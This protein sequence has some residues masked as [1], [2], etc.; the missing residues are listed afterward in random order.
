MDTNKAKQSGGN[1]WK[2]MMRGASP[3]G[4]GSFIL[5]NAAI[6]K[7]KPQQGGASL[8]QCTLP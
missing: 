7:T 8:I 1:E 6:R 5:Q 4:G 3:K 2:S